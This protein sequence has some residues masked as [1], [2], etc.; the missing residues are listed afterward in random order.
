MLPAQLI[1]TNS[2]GLTERAI[3]RIICGKVFSNA[4]HTVD[5]SKY[6]HHDRNRQHS[7]SNQQEPW[8]PV[9]DIQLPHLERQGS[10]KTTEKHSWQQLWKMQRN[11]V[12][13]IH[14]YCR[15]IATYAVPVLKY[16]MIMWLELG[17]D[18]QRLRDAS[19]CIITVC[20]SI[21]SIYLL[22][23]EITILSIKELYKL[24][25]LHYSLKYHHS[26]YPNYETLGK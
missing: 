16:T 25:D 7:G 10:Q 23:Q 18:T 3:S 11:D 2:K 6:T 21:Y 17:K 24:L 14:G 20:P 8:I 19:L 13:Q 26:N 15:P 22:H 1:Y 5:R 12:S 4:F 9:S